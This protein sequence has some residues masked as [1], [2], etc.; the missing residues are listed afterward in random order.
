LLAKLHAEAGHA[1][2]GVEQL[3]EGLSLAGVHEMLHI[4]Q[5]VVLERLADLLIGIVEVAEAVKV[6]RHHSKV[7]DVMVS[8]NLA[9]DHI[10]VGTVLL[11]GLQSRIVTLISVV[12][13]RLLLKVG[14]FRVARIDHCRWL[15]VSPH[16]HFV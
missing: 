12:L 13:R 16:A 8:E 10:S 3:A 11:L 5:R 2:L 6:G 4:L 9:E 14:E 7:I 15:S 1:L